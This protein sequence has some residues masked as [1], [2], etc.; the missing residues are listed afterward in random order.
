MRVFKA[1]KKLPQ[2]ARMQL[3]KSLTIKR[4]CVDNKTA[5][6]ISKQAPFDQPDP[7]RNVYLDFQSTTPLDPRVL[8][9]MLPYMTEKYG[10][11]HSVSHSYGW[12]ASKAVETARGHVARIIN[13][14]PK[15]V[16]FTSG[17]TESNNLAIKGVAEFYGGKKKHIITTQI[18]H[19]CVLDTCRN[20]E[21]KGFE[22]TYLPVQTNGILDLELLEKSI[23]KDTLLCSVINVHNE[24]GVIQPISQIGKICR[25]NGVFFHTDAAQAIGKIPVNVEEAN[26]DL[27][28]ISGHKVYGPKGIGG[29]YIRRK[30][31]VR[32]VPL[33]NGGGQER[34]F[35]S[36]TLPTHV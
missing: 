24:I 4:F 34:G 11:P 31:R 21:T 17:A 10:N 19:K 28:S 33:I 30:P 2:S 15:D 18:E 20:L 27:L 13:A 5:E 1:L 3:Q 9:I 26:I 12:E 35:R 6:D 32:L 36:G 29:L 14:D 16:I 7:K 8:D 22:V 25:K 23:R